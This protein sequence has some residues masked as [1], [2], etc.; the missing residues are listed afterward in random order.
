MATFL[1]IHGAWS[2]GWAWKK[3]R[4]LLRERGHEVFTP[5]CTGL[6]ERAHLANLEVDLDTHIAD[7]LAVLRVRGPARRGAGRPQL[8]R[9]GGHR[10]CRPRA[11]AHCSNWCTWTPSCRVTASALV[12]PDAG[13]RRA[14]RTSKPARS[15]GEG[16]RIPA[17]PMPPD[18]D[19]PRTSPGR[20]PRRRDAAAEVPSQQPLHLQAARSRRCRAA[21][22]TARAARPG[23]V[24]RPFAE[25][26]ATEQ[27][28]ALLRARRQPQPAHHDAGYAGRAAA[29]HRHA[30]A[31]QS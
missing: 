11:A 26:G 6:G 10:R 14:Q 23:D 29:S 7:M 2:A 20:L 15:R 22:S 30:A 3:M 8:R 25:R 16:W 5:T 12:R 24:F 19:A 17:N 27:R 1:I 9:H 31:R 18:T 4:P 21:T 28:L 13:R